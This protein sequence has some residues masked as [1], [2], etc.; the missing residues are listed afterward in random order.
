MMPVMVI[1]FTEGPRLQSGVAEAVAAARELAHS[2]PVTVFGALIG[3]KCEAAAA[4]FATTGLE[5]L[6]VADSPRHELYVAEPFIAAARELIARC[7]PRLVLLPHTFESAE[8]AP[9]LAG[10]LDA[11][12]ITDSRAIRWRD[13]RLVATKSICGGALEAEYV[14]D[15]SLAIVTLQAGAFESGDSVGSCPIERIE[16]PPVEARVKVLET[17]ADPPGVGP[18]LKN[19]RVVVAGGLG[20]GSRENWSI[21]TDAAAALGA[22]VGATRAVV[23]SG[24]VPSG[25]Q[26]G[27]SGVKVAPDLYIAL[28]ISGAVHHVAG[29]SQARVVV[30]VNSDPNAEIFKVARFGVVGDLKEVVPAFTARARTLR[31]EAQQE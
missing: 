21:V 8:W 1:G 18:T 14:L 5:R 4:S 28:G 20:I 9:Q 25:H 7:S 13:E 30:A 2:T 19:A 26:V 24:W 15:C 29:I 11:A 12:V 16:L 17:I 22:A 3:A 6:L 23:E 10:A 31:A 27:Y